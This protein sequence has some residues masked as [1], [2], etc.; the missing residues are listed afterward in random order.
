[1]IR[2]EDALARRD[3]LGGPTPGEDVVVSGGMAPAP[4][5]RP[6]RRWLIPLLTALAVVGLS[7]AAVFGTLY[8]R[9]EVSPEDVGGF[10]AGER[11]EVEERAGR[12]G[13]LLV[14]YDSTTLDDVARQMLEIATGNFREQYQEALGTG[15][16]LT[17][18]L[19]EAAASSRGQILEGPDVSFHSAS[20]AIAIMSVTQT[21]QSNA[22]PGG[23]T[24]NYTLK[25]TLIDTSDGGWKADRVE[26]LSTQQS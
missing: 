1:M 21:A 17:A 15:P 11:S 2:M 14:N 22:N 3:E 18:A 5:G 10:L 26:V 24:F 6:P 23:E 13:D 8:L 4:D 16:G 9:S 20:E 12:I 19:E 25:I 7:S